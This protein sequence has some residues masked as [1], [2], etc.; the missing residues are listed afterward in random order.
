MVNKFGGRIE[1]LEIKTKSSTEWVN[2][3][4]YGEDGSYSE[5][6][7]RN[8]EVVGSACYASPIAAQ[9][10]RDTYINL[11]LE[12]K[13]NKSVLLNLMNMANIEHYEDND[14]V[15][16]YLRKKDEGFGLHRS[17]QAVNV[18]KTEKE[19]EKDSLNSKDLEDN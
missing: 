9:Q 18:R 14:G 12:D 15:I 17:S 13:T 4:T 8:G 10:I 19:I 16:I 1:I 2:S 7:T 5:E 11:D 6:W 3:K